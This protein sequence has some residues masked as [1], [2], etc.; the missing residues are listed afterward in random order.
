MLQALTIIFGCVFLILLLSWLCFQRYRLNRPA[1]GVMNLLD[2]AFMLVVIVLIPVLYIYLPAGVMIVTLTIAAASGLYMLLEVVLPNRVLT[3]LAMLVLIAAD[4]WALNFY[5]VG[6]TPFFAVNNAV[7]VL[8]IVSIT[9]LWAQSGMKASA[10]AILGLTLMAYDFVF[11]ALLPFMGDLFE[12]LQ[13]VPFSPMI[14]WNTGAGDQWIG[15]GFGDLAMAAVFP[16]VMRKAYGRPA[17]LVALAGALSVFVVG[18]GL[19]FAD[20]IG[21]TFPLMVLLGPLMAGQ[22]LFWRNRRGKERTMRAFLKAELKA[23]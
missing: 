8:V 6:S 14:A 10:V 16:L 21:D 20:L 22:Y 13:Y 11:T 15:I 19:A 12:Q 18:V 9:N 23:Q 1:I 2:V 3:W 4:L 17:G 5:G 7:Q